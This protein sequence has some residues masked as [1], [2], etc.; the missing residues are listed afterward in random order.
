MQNQRSSCCCHWRSKSIMSSLTWMCWARGFIAAIDYMGFL[1]FLNLKLVLL[2]MWPVMFPL[3]CQIVRA[4]RN[5]A[6]FCG[7]E[8]KWL[9]VHPQGGHMVFRSEAGPSSFRCVEMSVIKFTEH[10]ELCPFSY[11]YTP[12]RLFHGLGAT[13][14]SLVA[15]KLGDVTLKRAF[16]LFH[17][18]RTVL[19][20]KKATS[21][22]SIST[23]LCCRDWR[24]VDQ[25]M[26]IRES[27]AN[28]I[29][30][31]TGSDWKHRN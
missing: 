8:G 20:K 22:I 10:L 17:T 4:W 14:G 19:L 23:S 18:V 26:D 27:S 3:L 16:H 11:L 1:L 13:V 31:S 24:K 28:I 30:F 15:E 6:G 25:A 9:V 12:G 5:C 7:S 2:V 29:K 21:F